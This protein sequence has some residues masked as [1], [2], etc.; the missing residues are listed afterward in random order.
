MQMSM[1]PSLVWVVH[2]HSG[3]GTHSSTNLAEA[4]QWLRSRGDR[5]ATLVGLEW[6]TGRKMYEHQF[7]PAHR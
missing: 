7:D 4:I 2:W 3:D 5:G 1:L 6:Q